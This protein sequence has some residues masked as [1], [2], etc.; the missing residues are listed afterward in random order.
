VL[1]ETALHK[2]FGS[3]RTLRCL[4]LTTCVVNVSLRRNKR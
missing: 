4:T 1:L 2:D 3:G